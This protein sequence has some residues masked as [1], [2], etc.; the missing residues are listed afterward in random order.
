M[1]NRFKAHAL[2]LQE[3]N[4]AA[5]AMSFLVTIDGSGKAFTVHPG[6]TVLAASTRAGVAL[7]YSCVAGRCGSCRAQLQRGSVHYPYQPPFAL[8]AKERAHGDVLLCQAVPTTDLSIAIREVEQV[9]RYKPQ[10]HEIVLK[11]RVQ[12]AP[13]IFVLSFAIPAALSWL[14]GQYLNFVLADGKK[15]AFSIASVPDQRDALSLHVRH[16]SGGS[17][18][19]Q[20]CGAVEIGTQF[21]IEAPLGTC[22]PRPESDRPL[23]LVAGGTGYGPIRCLAA[24]FAAAAPTRPITLYRGARA[25]PELYLDEDAQQ[26][27]ALPNARYVRVLSDD[28]APGTRYGLVHDIVLADHPDLRQY[29]VYMSGPPGMIDA[30]RHAFVARGLPPE[31]LYYDSFEFAP[32]VLAAI[33]SAK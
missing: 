10:L 18:T 2:I 22:V 30:A 15:R 9:A 8:D 5:N 32:D 14:P 17:F 33:L 20:L 6:E 31:R 16:V 7:P 12:V 26:L 21:T 19:E 1:H 11:Q 25:R 27:F 28:P 24:H 29:D 13:E 3:P 4:L 23:I